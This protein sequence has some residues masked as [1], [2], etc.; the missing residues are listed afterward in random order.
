M[1]DQGSVRSPVVENGS[2]WLRICE[3]PWS[4]GTTYNLIRRGLLQTV[5]VTIE[6]SADSRGI[7]L[8]SRKSLD[9]FLSRLSQQQLE[10]PNEFGRKRRKTKPEELIAA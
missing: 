9:E 5:R 8:V 6:G 3:L 4:K 7:R 10:D 2:D 1:K